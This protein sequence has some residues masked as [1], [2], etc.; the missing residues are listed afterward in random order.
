[1]QFILT[2]FTQ[3]HEFRVFAFEGIAADRV[4]TPLLSGRT[5]H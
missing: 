5:L 3:D 1:M 2:G 4:R